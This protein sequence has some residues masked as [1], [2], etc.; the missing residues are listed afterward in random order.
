MNK[1]FIKSFIYGGTDGIITIF[2]IISGIHGANLDKL[3]V[4]ILGFGTL[5]AD[6]VSMGVSSYISSKSDKSKNNFPFKNGIITFISFILFGL[7]PLLSFMFITNNKISNYHVSL[8]IS[9]LS[10]TIL[11]IIQALITK[12]NIFKT[13]LTTSSIGMFG[14][15][16]SYNIA[17]YISKYIKLH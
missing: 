6:A 3:Y 8:V 9:L 12:T 7:V 15:L 2:N 10:M 14:A 17:K 4:I 1:E 11:G 13:A 5:V 16:L